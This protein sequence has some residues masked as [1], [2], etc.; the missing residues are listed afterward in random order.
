[1]YVYVNSSSISFKKHLRH[2]LV[3]TISIL[4]NSMICSDIW[5]KYLDWY[6]E[7]VMR[8]FTSC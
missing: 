4:G 1:M 2:L 7:I 5:H 3:I 6:F 8:N